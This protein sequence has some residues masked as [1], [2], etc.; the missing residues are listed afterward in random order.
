MRMLL[1]LA[2][3]ALTLST[4]PRPGGGIGQGPVTD[5]ANSDIDFRKLTPSPK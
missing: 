3:T 2:A 5:R 1:L 4:A